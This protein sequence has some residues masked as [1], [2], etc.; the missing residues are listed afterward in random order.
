MRDYGKVFTAF[1]TSSDVLAMNEDERTLALYLLTCPHGNMLGCYRLPV[2]YVAEDLR[3]A[4]ER[5]A[6]A[7][8][9]LVSKDYLHRCEKTQWT[10]IKRYLKWNLFENP[11]VG[12]AA[13]RLYEGLSVP[14][15][16]RAVLVEAILEYSQHF[17]TRLLELFRTLSNSVHKGDGN[18]FELSS[19]GLKQPFQTEFE[20]QNQNQSLTGATTRAS[21]EAGTGTGTNT[22]VGQNQ[23]DPV[24]VIFG[25]WQERMS[26]P[27][28]KLDDK[29]RR[30]IQKA[31]TLYEP[32]DICRAIRGCS[33]TP[34]NMGKNN[35]NTK[36]NG[37]NLILRD[38][39]HID[40][41][42]RCD[43][44]QPTAGAESVEEM[45]ARIEQEFLADGQDDGSVIEM[46]PQ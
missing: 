41:F 29:R 32:S 6:E 38:A 44:G 26:S 23:P 34:Y 43:D 39:D 24:V 27:K 31:M 25:Y 3:W 37:L 30:L 9:G 22:N 20:N 36:Y 15:S 2:A 28:S 19:E 12:K 18:P 17:P 40:H 7:L 10:V 46:E 5:A 33:R 45:N 4:Q 13:G 42:I 1:W 35:S 11:N 16:V 21:T 14:D 8:A